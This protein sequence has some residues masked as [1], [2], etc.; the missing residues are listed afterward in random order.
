MKN[1]IHPC[2]TLALRYYGY[3]IAFIFFNLWTQMVSAQCVPTSG[4]IDGIVFTDTNNNGVR[5]VTEAGLQGVMVQ[6]YD[7]NGAL[8]GTSTSD[9]SGLFSFVGLTDGDK[10]RLVYNYANA[11]FP[12]LL[13]TNNGSSVQF[14]Q[15]PM[16]NV[17]FGLA[18]DADM[19]NSKTEILTTCFVQGTTLVRQN[20]PTIVGI[21]Y[22]FNSAT[23][24][25]KFAMH[26]ETG[27]IWG[28]VWKQ[29]TQEIFSSAFVKQYSGLKA[30][31]DAIFRTAFNGSMYTTSVFANLSTLGQSVGSL[32]V[33]DVAD[34]NY[35]N[36]VGRIGIG[37]MV[38]SPD[39]K[40]LYVVN[41]Y[42]NTIVRVPTVSPT[43]ANTVAYQIPGSGV[44]AFALKYYNDKIYVGLTAPGS[45][46]TILVFDP[47]SGTFTDSGLSIPAGANW[48]NTPVVGGAPSHWLTD[49]DFTDDGDMLLS[50]SDRI[51]HIYCN[52]LS[53]RLDEQKGDLM[54]AK[55]NGS[56]W[57]LEDRSGGNEFFNE[58]FWTA[59]PTYHSEITIGS[60]FAMPG[61][62]SVVATVFDPE[63]NTYSGGLHRYN[64]S[65]GKKEAG[66]EL[67]TRETVNLFGKATGFGEIIATCGLP[68]IE[69]GNL[70]WLDANA[71]G[72]Q[73]ADEAGLSGVYVTLYDSNCNL[74]ATDITDSKG[75][76]A[77]NNSNVAGGLYANTNYFVGIDKSH[78]DGETGLFTF[79]N[80]LFSVTKSIGDFQALNSDAATTSC[81]SGLI[82]VNIARTSH[83]FDL[84]FRPE[85]E[86]SLRISKKVNN[87]NEVKINDVVTFAISVV[88]NGT[89]VISE[90]DI[91]DKLPVGYIFDPSNN[92]G[93]AIENGLLK[94]TYDQRLTQGQ[95]A[96]TNLNLTFAKNISNFQFNNEAKISGAKDGS[97]KTISDI[98]SCFVLPE[99]GFSNDLPKVCDLA[100][101]HTTDQVLLNLPNRA[102]TFTTTICNQGTIDAASY[103]I[104]NYLNSTLDFD[105]SINT[106]WLISSDLTR[107]TYDENKV[108]LPGECRDYKLYGRV[109]EGITASKIENYAE[110]S[111]NACSNL[112]SNDDFDSTPDNI[113]DNDKGGQPNTAN[114]NK[115]D[116]HGDTDEDDHDPATVNLFLYDL[117]LTKT[118]KTRRASAGDEI[119]FDLTIRNVGQSPVSGVTVVDYVPKDTDLKD[120][121]WNLANGNAVKQISFPGNLAAGQT[122]V[123]QCTLKI[124]DNVR[125]P[126]TISNTAE[127]TQIF[128][129]AGND[130]SEL[131][132]GIIDENGDVPPTSNLKDDDKSTAY[133]VLICPAEYQPCSDCRAATTPTNGQFIVNLKI[134]SKEGETW[135][136]ESSVGLFDTISPFPP[137]APT[138]LTNG[139]QLEEYAHEHDGHSY[140]LL[141]AIHLDKKGFSVRLRNEFGDL[142]QVTAGPATCSFD[143]IDL[144]GPQSMCVGSTATY[145]ANS[146][147]PGATYTWYVDDVLVAGVAGTSLNQDWTGFSQGAHVVKV[148]AIPGC[149][150]P[151]EL[152][153]MIGEADNAAIACI[154]DFNVSL[155]GNCEIVITPS[156]MVAGTLNA[157]SPYIVMLTDSHGNPIPNA[158]LTGEHAGTKVMA[159]LI[160]SCGGN[161]CWSTITVE[162]KTA[163][164]SICN[165]IVL[166]CYKLDEYKGPFETDNCGGPVKNEIISE[167][168]T[169]L[170]CDNDFVKYIDRVYQATDKF[171]NKSALC[172]MRISLE[173]P[174][175]DLIKMPPS[176]TMAKDS[177][178]VCDD[179]D[180]DEF[181]RPDPSVT[182]V[183]TLAGIALYPT[184][185]EICN[186]VSWYK[187]IDHGTINCVRKITREWFVYEQWCSDGQMLTYKQIIEITDTIP[188]VIA[189]IPNF[190]V[191]TNSQS[192]CEGAVKLPIAS[193]TDICSNKLKVDVTYPG[194]FID[195]FKGTESILLPVG[196]HII[197]YTA[198]D[199]CKNSASKSFTVTV[200]DKT[201]PTVI[202]KGEV[203]VGLNSNGQA[204]LSP[205]NVDDGSFDGCG[206]GRMKIAKMVPS[207]LI[208]DSLFVNSIDFGCADVGRSIMVALRVWD[209][210][211]NSNSCMINVTIQDKHAPK[212]T[213]PADI[214][215]DCK[216]VFSGMDLTQYGKAIAIDACGAT[217]TEN[218]AKFILNSCRVGTIE[219]NFVATDGTIP[220][221]CKQIITVVNSD[222]FNPL[223]DVVKPLDYEVFDRCSVLELKPENLPALY[224]NPI[225]TQ[226]SCGLAA[227]SYK[228]DVY[229]FVA[230]A[231]YK[232]VRNW[233]IIDWCEMERLGASYTPYTFQQIIKV[234]NTVPPFFVGQAPIDQ[235]FF[236]DK[237]NCNEGA[238]SLTFI[239]G[240]LCTPNNQLR[241]SFKIDYNNDGSIN[242][243]NNG[244]GHIASIVNTLFPVGTHKILWSFED[245][246]GNVTTRAHL[247]TVR[248]NDKPTAAGLESIAVAIIPWDTNGDG[249]ADVEKACI[250]AASLNVSSSSLCC[251][252]PLRFSYSADINDTI[253]CFTCYHVGEDNIVELWVHDCNGNTD[254]V[255]V[256][257]DVQ[258]NNDSNVCELICINNPAVVNVTGILSICN[259]QSTTLTATG[260]LTYHWN[261]GET[262]ASITVSPNSTRDYSVTITNEFRCTDADTVTVT[263]NPLP[264]VMINGNNVCNGS[265]TILSATGGGTYIWNNG[266]TSANITV[267]PITN[268]TYTVTVTSSQ[269]CTASTSRLVIV[270]PLP[271][272]SINGIQSICNGSNTTLTAAGGGTYLWS[273]NG[274]T[275]AAITVSPTQNT[276][277][278]VTVTSVQGCTASSSRTVTVNGLTINAIISGSDEVCSGQPTTLT[279]SLTG[280]TANSYIWSNNATTSAINV[281]PAINTTYTVTITDNNGCT[282]TASKLVTVKALPIVTVTGPDACQ[283]GSTTLT[284]T[285]GGTYFWS[286]NATTASI[287]VT[288]A[289]PTTYSVTVTGANGCS[290]VGSKQVNINP[291]PTVNISGDNAICIN[292]SATLTA[293][294]GVNYVWSNSATT[295]A[296]TVSPL[297]TTTYTVTA[298]DSNGCT[299]TAAIT[300]TVSGLTIN[301]NIAGSDTICVGSSTTLTA[302]L[303]GGT[304]MSYAWSF[305]N[306]T[307]QS[308]TVNPVVTTTYTV[309]ITDTNGCN[310]TDAITVAVN[311]LP[312]IVISGDKTICLGESTTLT[313]TGAISY[314]WNTGANTASIS[315]TPLVNTS[316]TVTA[317][318]ANGCINTTISNVV[319]NP[320]PEILIMGNDTVCANTSTQL[321]ASGATSY[322]WSTGATTATTVVIPASTATYTVTGTDAN[323]CLN[324]A[325]IFVTV[326]PNPTPII[327]GDLML[328]LGDTTILSTSGGGT[329][330]WST[331]ATSSSIEVFPVVNTTYSVTVTDINGCKGSTSATVI[332]DPGNLTCTTQNITVYLDALGTV[333]IT[334]MDISTGSVGACTN[335]E[336]F[337]AP[338][339]LNCN[340]I[341]VNPTIVTLTVVNTNTR[342]TLTCTAEVT[343]LDTLP[344]VLVCPANMVLNCETFDPNAPLSNYGIPTFGD[345]CPASLSLQEVPVIN[346]GSCNVGQ[347]TRTFIVTDFSGNSTQCVQLIDVVNPDPLVV[348]D[349]N[350]PADVTISNCASTSIANTGNTTVNASQF[351][352]AG[353]TISFTD[354]IPTPL[355]GGTYQRIWTVVDSCQTVPGT[356]QGIFVHTQTII[357]NVQTPEILGPTSTVILQ[358][359]AVTCMAT[360][361]GMNHSATGCNLVLS[362]NINNNAN[363]DVTGVYPNGQT[364]VTLVATETC[365]GLSDTLSFIIQVDTIAM[366]IVCAKTYPIMTDQLFVEENVYEH[367][368][369]TQDCNTATIVASFTN[370]FIYDTL[371]IYDCSDLAN[372][373]IGITIYFWY[374]GA[375][376]PFTLCQS[377]VG[378]TDP[379]DFCGTLRTIDGS[380]TTESGQAV[381]N[382]TIDLHGSQMPA[383]STLVNGQ[384]NFPEMNGGGEYT[385]I[386]SR[387]DN[388]LEGVSTLDLIYIQKHILGSE[389]LN[390]PYKIIAADINKD[391]KVSSSDL[392]QLRK[393]ILGIQENFPNNTSWRMVDKGYSFPDPKEPFIGNI[394]ENYYIESLNASMDIDWIGV[395][396]G[397]VNNSYVTRLKSDG[398][399]SRSASLQFSMPEQQL[400]TGKNIIPV[401]ASATTDMAGF[402]ISLPVQGVNGILITNGLLSMTE[403]NFALVNGVLNISWHDAKGIDV[404]EGDILFFLH[405]DAKT[406]SNLSNLLFTDANKGL[407]PEYYNSDHQINK[408]GWRVDRG[409]SETFIVHGNTPNPWNNE[410]SINFSLPQNGDVSLKVRD[411]TGRLIYTSSNYYQKGQNT[412]RVSSDDLGVSGLLFYD[413]TFGKEVKTMKM[414][415]IK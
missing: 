232:I 311:P 317:T 295:A 330:S 97:G 362:N 402:Q 325:S 170:T 327:A 192:V 230:G 214:D 411:I 3:V 301:A 286:N 29:R 59:N 345:N 335:I 163:P 137:I 142:E 164:I 367:A 49:I 298:T 117:S 47:Q 48:T 12:S 381:P 360:Y 5:N 356:T 83:H 110:I 108:L 67:Y 207:G 22:G 190:K 294:G 388:P 187:D 347:I 390:S 393:V 66:K 100:L 86:C 144:S 219:R 384:Y 143:R 89:R 279:S 106:G 320:L 69:I 231:C 203:V 259:G 373:P 315:V 61:T 35:G 376:A 113:S 131:P 413:L 328:C 285:G 26:G 81:P 337:V 291:L 104:T 206:I 333:N 99:D 16:C 410:T 96:T 238:V 2:Q 275:T 205:K 318:D 323:G 242:S 364:L 109:K 398:T 251:D 332:V 25:R 82:A 248:N 194:G 299:N 9:G 167:D 130:V 343:V 403:D 133:V 79:N 277:Y 316:Y 348:G 193:V 128:D 391:N 40:Y 114:D 72:I 139:F 138:P 166:P 283:G 339:M 178:L 11:N 265:S 24:A 267:S 157:T 126:A 171:G 321:T 14:V 329:Y 288:P 174:N 365:S 80:E 252:E 389:S 87:Q 236:T 4:T 30:G 399:E 400:I 368:T 76:Y 102:V 227:A 357:V 302:S 408:L 269:G 268:T 10:I 116:D 64:T 42:N 336:A 334:P 414:L 405:I 351:D 169:V 180:V 1:R 266:A 15:V 409:R 70:I 173:R 183:P 201:A 34:C 256:N 135:Y 249:T 312:N 289:S 340:D 148:A 196:N 349:I 121:T 353:L 188:P 280:G 377:L 57:V 304:A 404:N 103:Q 112:T 415:N 210:N 63:I 197:N 208:P 355:C 32:V 28:L 290:A 222:Y 284:A 282:D 191:T 111:R 136:V 396:I 65:T 260:G 264:T 326:N 85:G 366:N 124:H 211:G 379:N 151:A 155:N 154:G 95:T 31:H 53:N 33:T 341:Q 308:I 184:F 119:I 132:V 224:G 240:D 254:F 346:I 92:V 369:I 71:N 273:F 18:S 120:P 181:G 122:Y 287:T 78:K 401:Y 56:G 324:D 397:D 175:F 361:S 221:T 213:C 88:N 145:K 218:A 234:N 407:N 246:C 305:N 247:V 257:V 395:K 272:A 160:E 255:E 296:I 58:D 342:D 271:Q 297:V 98:T 165:D 281:A 212:I 217:V 229:N 41:I 331:T 94:Y 350:F 118:I 152:T 237:G 244:I 314:L 253:R 179:F 23:P 199:E 387:N 392:V 177:A 406:D 383:V 319:V 310:G 241:W 44:H 375:S 161:S 107:L 146:S 52:N 370:T 354:N 233:T 27:A 115:M 338:N 153:V 263:V 363:F 278:T 77:F 386:P 39:E 127:I 215:I 162:D 359:D 46:M 220:A 68:E 250:T 20:E 45:V 239:G 394:A 274:A 149:I 195:G 7:P 21:E 19:C 225:I 13:G 262:T 228:D 300:V 38:L 235:T 73:D 223:T 374:E 186:T 226:S 129:P 159:K 172:E 147:I 258:D 51:G 125:H 75:N 8:L 200:E 306:A 270:N 141:R 134:A 123:T 140:Y 204:Y 412:I 55:K 101:K 90:V 168:I 150:A 93:W 303:T 91:T 62:N 6:A 261:T 344:P 209:E 84:G 358:K 309:T 378:L 198:Y 293:S 202:C 243:S 352:C 74:L 380:V 105:P 36:Q 216:D 176:Y 185:A 156:M 54:I 43:S 189:T 322:V 245:Q 382:V 371:A 385:V 60:I 182:G 307:T 292:E 158:T 37:S 372:A 276:T 313:A 17:G 50:L